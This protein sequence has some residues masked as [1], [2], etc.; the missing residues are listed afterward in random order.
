M[1][2]LPLSGNFSVS[3]PSSSLT[4]GLIIQYG[5]V[6]NGINANPTNEAALGSIVITEPS[7]VGINDF[8]D[9][10]FS[11]YP[12]PTNNETAISSNNNISELIVRDVLGETVLNFNNL[13]CKTKKIDLS[14]LSANFYF[15]EVHFNNKIDIKKLIIVK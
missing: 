11:L 4:A 12:N 10:S 6:I 9:V 2:D 15:I 14:K 3:V 5:F 8:N 13:S 7:T 1:M